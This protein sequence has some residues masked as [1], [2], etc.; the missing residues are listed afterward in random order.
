MRRLIEVRKA[1]RALGRGTFSMPHPG[2]RKVFAYV[3]ENEGEVVLCAANLARSAQPV[4][5]DLGR[6][7][8]CVP[9]ELLGGSPF[10]PIGEMR[11]F[12]TL[13]GHGVYWFRL[14]PEAEAPGW[15]QLR[16]PP[17]ELP[18]LA[19]TEWSTRSGRWL[20]TVVDVQVRERPPQ[21]YALPLAL[22]WEGR[23]EEPLR[24]LAP[25][26]LARVR[27]RARMGVLYD[28]IY[29]DAFCWSVLTAIG[30]GEQVAVGAGS[31]RFS[32][33]AAYP[34]LVASLPAEP[35]LRRLSEPDN[36][37]VVFGE[38]QLLK[39]SPRRRRDPR[40]VLPADERAWPADRRA[41]HSARRGAWRPRL[42]ARAHRPRGARCLGRWRPQPPARGRRD[43]RIVAPLPRRGLESVPGLRPWERISRPKRACP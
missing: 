5:L 34:G 14:A 10:P 22:A 39:G 37:G 26:T 1:H 18:V 33:T 30:A 3:R 6:S 23:D 35:A 7:R 41:A 15:H 27:Q 31:L 40:R 28:A 19:M 13:P 29:D 9:V 20:L 17:V 43:A 25:V 12:L 24:A 2:N 11:Y 38:R 32:A 36:N 42:R 21:R 8:G 4:E 16:L